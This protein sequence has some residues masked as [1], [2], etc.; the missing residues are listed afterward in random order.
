MQVC[1]IQMY[2]L[3]V[4]VIYIFVELIAGEST[5]SGLSIDNAGAAYVLEV[6]CDGLDDE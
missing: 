3:N 6:E 2:N 5:I 4:A 1:D